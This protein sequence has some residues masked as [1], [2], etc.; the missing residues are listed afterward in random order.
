M[1][2]IPPLT[3]ND[4]RL[5]SSN[6][7][8]PDVGEPAE[9]SAVTTYNTG[10]EVGV[11]SVQANVHRIYE[12]LVDSNTGNNP[13][14]DTNGVNWLDKGPTNRHKMLD[15]GNATQ[16]VE[17][18]EID[19]TITPGTIVNGLALLNIQGATARII[20]DDVGNEGVVYDKTYNLV[21]DSGINDWYAYFF[22]PIERK[23][24]LVITDLPSYANATIRIIVSESGADVKVG[25]LVIGYQRTI[26]TTNYGV[27]SSL[28]DYSTKETD[29]FGNFIVNEKP[30]S[31]RVDFPVTIN[32]DRADFIQTLLAKYRATPIIWI[33]RKEYGTTVVY[34]YFRD[35]DIIL[36]SFQISDCN[37][38]VEGLT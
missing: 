5:T 30:Y 2:I 31:E 35:L 13:W 38:T 27:S 22:T 15:E 20:M 37:L 32:T 9:Y 26:G 12:S 23:S 24:K 6:V 34:G 8:E 14:E 17:Y 11:Y 4:T 7:P 21:D 18:E 28:K 33:G 1:L 29:T 36:T 19:L 25:T 10:D 16:T 3:I